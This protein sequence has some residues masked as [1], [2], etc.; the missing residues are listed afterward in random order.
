MLEQ[1]LNQLGPDPR[2]DDLYPTADLPDLEDRGPD[3]LVGV[4]ALAGNLLAPGQDGLRCPQ[5]YRSRGP[6]DPRH[7]P[8]HHLADLLLEL[9]VDGISL[10]F[11]D[12]LD[13][14]LLGGLCADAA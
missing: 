10:S 7:H 11:T 1:P 12:L 4:V 3:P 13:D 2:Q 8:R 9:V 6:F 5:R 14:H